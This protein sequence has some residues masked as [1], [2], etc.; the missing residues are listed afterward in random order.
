MPLHIIEYELISNNRTDVRNEIINLFLLE[1]PGAGKKELSSKYHYIVEHYDKYQIV[2]QRPA[3]L[4]K[5][6]DFTVNI[7]G[8]YFKNNKRYTYPRHNDIINILSDVTLTYTEDEYRKVIEQIHAVFDCKQPNLNSIK[9]I[10]FCDYNE[11]KRPIAII[12]LAIK[13]LFIEQDVTYWNWSGRYMLKTKLR[14][15]GL[16]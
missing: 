13:W 8:M 9:D 10:Y 5:G 1:K 2:L 15:V 14:E 7:N 11:V 16:A 6:F 12:V 4:N 3:L